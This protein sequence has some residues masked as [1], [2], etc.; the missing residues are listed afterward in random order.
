MLMPS[1]LHNVGLFSSGIRNKDPHLLADLL[2]I[3]CL[4]DADG[5]ISLNEG[6]DEL[7]GE[8]EGL[9]GIGEDDSLADDVHALPFADAPD[10]NDL[11]RNDRKT[12]RIGDV[13][14]H[15]RARAE[16]FHDMYPFLSL[17]GRISLK[18]QPVTAHKLYVFMLLAANL[19][20]FARTD[21][22]MLTADF[23]IL[24]ALSLRE[25]FPC[26]SL[27]LFGTARCDTLESYTGSPRAKLEAF[28]QN[29]GLRLLM[30]EDELR[31][32]E[33][34]GGDA[35]LDVVAWHPFDDNAAHM[36]V[37]LAQVGCTAD[38]QK[39]FEKQYASSPDRWKNKLRGLAAFGCMVTP[40]CYRNADNSW[41]CFTDVHS[42]FLD[43]FRVLRLLQANSD[44]Y[45]SQLSSHAQVESIFP[46]GHI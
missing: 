35:G 12:N 37:L 44:T 4:Q 11:D 16:L 30:E 45:F 39:M 24:A 25:I 7:L 31:R 19:R 20:Y 21:R 32:L 34:P 9:G 36:P 18:A 46:A 27:R 8:N 5:D 22:A 17:P 43:R 23:E 15:L 2:E 3:A 6:L 29:L 41:P 40:Q 26:W 33:T 42:I 38:E 13:G 1:F 28:A 14:E 10:R